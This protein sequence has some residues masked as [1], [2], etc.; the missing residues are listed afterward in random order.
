MLSTTCTTG[1]LSLTTV[2]SLSSADGTLAGALHRLEGLD[3]LAHAVDGLVAAVDRPPDVGHRCDRQPDRVPTDVTQ[4]EAQLVARLGHRHVETIVVDADRDGEVVPG[5]V[6]RHERQRRRFGRVLPQVRHRHA[7]EV[8][9][10]VGQSPLVQGADVDEDLAESLARAG[11]GLQGGGHLCL[12]HHATGHEDVPQAALGG[13]RVHRR[14]LEGRQRLVG[15]VG[16][17]E[18]PEFGTVLTLERKS[19]AGR[20]WVFFLASNSHSRCTW[21]E[22]AARIAGSAHSPCLSIVGGS[23][24]T[25]ERRCRDDPEGPAGRSEG[26][27]VPRRFRRLHDPRGV[28]STRRRM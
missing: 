20:L 4:Q 16:L 19:V 12:G 26:L 13:R 18:R 17:G 3:E 11:L 7:E 15:R 5:D 24:R 1:A 23:F 10:G 22:V 6:R 25:L 28:P 9:E 27:R 2:G 8:R 14:C 21:V